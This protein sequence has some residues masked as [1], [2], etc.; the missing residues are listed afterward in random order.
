MEEIAEKYPVFI[1]VIADMVS[2]YIKIQSNK[3]NRVKIIDS[4][5]DIRRLLIED[6]YNFSDKE[7]LKNLLKTDRAYALN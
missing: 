3:I 6:D 4:I 7:L 5:S 2:E 1:D